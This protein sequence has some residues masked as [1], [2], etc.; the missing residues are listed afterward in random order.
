MAKRF[1]YYYLQLNA[2][3]A[4]ETLEQS[5]SVAVMN[6]GLADH[7]A[8]PTDA[9]IRIVGANFDE[10]SEIWVYEQLFYI[11]QLSIDLGLSEE[12][13]EAE[14]P[15]SGTVDNTDSVDLALREERL[16]LADEAAI[17][18]GTRDGI[19]NQDGL[20]SQNEASAPDDDLAT[21]DHDSEDGALPWANLN[22]PDPSVRGLSHDRDDVALDETVPWMRS[23]AV[24]DDDDE[25]LKL[26][27][28]YPFDPPRRGGA[29]VKILAFV[30]LF[31][32][33]TVG[34]VAG[35]LIY[36]QHPILLDTADKFGVGKYLKHG[37]HAAM[38]APGGRN[39]GV[40]L[41]PQAKEEVAR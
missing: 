36:L 8:S 32:F 1:E 19:A 2:G 21:V 13:D 30:F 37:P 40:S 20:V 22:A 33:L 5:D 41:M 9:E 35:A 25:V 38:L 27:E 28:A 7:L 39:A 24:D 4:W 3:L 18:D 26:S 23:R 15:F 12:L 17:E 34:A 10:K 6:T 11:D 31:L 14:M 16:S 29:I